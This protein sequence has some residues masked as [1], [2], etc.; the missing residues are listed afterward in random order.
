MADREG[1]ESYAF[2]HSHEYRRKAVRWP[3]FTH[4]R[5]K[6]NNITA[7]DLIPGGGTTQ[8]GLNGR[9]AV[10]LFSD[11]R[12]SYVSLSGRRLGW[13]WKWK[14]AL[15]FFSDAS[16]CV[17]CDIPGKKLQH[18]LS[19]YS[20]SFSHFWWRFCYCVCAVSNAHSSL[21][22]SQSGQLYRSSLEVKGW[23]LFM[24]VKIQFQKMLKRPVWSTNL[25]LEAKIKSILSLNY[26]A[27]MPEKVVRYWHAHAVAN[28]QHFLVICNIPSL[29]PLP[30]RPQY[31]FNTRSRPYLSFWQQH[32]S[33]W[34]LRGKK[35]VFCF[36]N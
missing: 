31:Q 24:E 36:A 32:S 22:S 11:D 29:P 6:N 21:S 28:S 2:P 34:M 14:F 18:A 3:T 15:P 13:N 25:Q 23:I 12:Y 26:S 33:Q 1:E 19:S 7:L 35:I 17:L 30:C 10:I 4:A 16:F 27:K 20:N 5:A 9:S 8:E